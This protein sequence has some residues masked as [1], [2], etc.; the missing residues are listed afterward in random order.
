MK[1][2]RALK[3][4]YSETI[5]KLIKC[6]QSQCSV[7][8]CECDRYYMQVSGVAKKIA[9]KVGKKMKMGIEYNAT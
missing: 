4:I 8:Q 2:T 1:K 6:I 7:V 3:C 5:Y 9:E